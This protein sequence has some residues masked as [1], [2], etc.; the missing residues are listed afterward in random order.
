[1]ENLLIVIS[2]LLLMLRSVMPINSD[3]SLKD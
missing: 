1:M 2:I 3:N